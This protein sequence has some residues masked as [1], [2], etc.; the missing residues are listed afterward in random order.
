MIYS[1]DWAD[2][3]VWEDWT[4]MVFLQSWLCCNASIW[5]ITR[6]TTNFSASL[7]CKPVIKTL[8]SL[9]L[10]LLFLRTFYGCQVK[11]WVLSLNIKFFRKSCHLGLSCIRTSGQVVVAEISGEAPQHWVNFPTFLWW[12]SLGK[13]GLLSAVSCTLRNSLGFWAR[14][15]IILPS[16]IGQ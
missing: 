7:F 4:P 13:L 1:R 10:W 2:P 8:V 3:Y 5:P 11:P 15:L 9:S 14:I 6:V 12:W 16:Q